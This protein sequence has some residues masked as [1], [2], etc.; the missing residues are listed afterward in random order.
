MSLSEAQV[1]DKIE[2]IENGV[3]QVRVA[4]RVFRDGEVIAQNY[5]RFMVEPGQDISTL[6]TR[7]QAICAAVHTSEVVAAWQT[8]QERIAAEHAAKQTPQE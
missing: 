8:E 6:D 5:S 7:V 4:N 1:I 3:V 2:V